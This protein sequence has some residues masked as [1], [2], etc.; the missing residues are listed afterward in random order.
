MMATQ[1]PCEVMKLDKEMGKIA[2][3]QRA[4]IIA[5]DLK[6]YSCKLVNLIG[7]SKYNTNI[8]DFNTY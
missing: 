2:K 8:G 3:G 6:D 4:D 1:T 5:M 7:H